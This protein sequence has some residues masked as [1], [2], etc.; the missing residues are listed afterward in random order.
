MLLL[1]FAL[2]AEPTATTSG[3]PDSSTGQPTAATS[4]TADAPS[5]TPLLVINGTV[6]YAQEYASLQVGNVYSTVPGVTGGS[7]AGTPLGDVTVLVDGVFLDHRGFL[8]P[9]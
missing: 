7:F 8:S 2:A 1:A 5:E 4:S 9:W 6:H 3:L